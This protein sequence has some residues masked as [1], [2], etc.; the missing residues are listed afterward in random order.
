[1]FRK[2]LLASVLAATTLSAHAEINTYGEAVKAALAGNP[3]VVGSYY[4]YEASAEARKVTRGDFLPKVDIQ[5]R[6]G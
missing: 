6:I 4:E 2:P 5:G 3:A 1:V